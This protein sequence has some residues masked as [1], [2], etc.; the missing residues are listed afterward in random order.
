VPVSNP[1]R[2]GGV[3]AVEILLV[4]LAETRRI[5]LRVLDPQ[6][7]VGVCRRRR[8]VDALVK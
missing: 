8:P 3:D 6:P 1:A 2:D 7:V 4:E 5:A